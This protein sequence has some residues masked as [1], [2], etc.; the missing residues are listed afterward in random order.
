VASKQA[1]KQASKKYKKNMSTISDTFNQK[2]KSKKNNKEVVCFE[3]TN[4][5]KK[6]STTSSRGGG[7]AVVVAIEKRPPLP[8]SASSNNSND[9]NTNSFPN[10]EEWWS[11]WIGFLTF[12]FCTCCVSQQ[13]SPPT[14]GRWESN[15]WNAFDANGWYEFGILIVF[16]GIGFF[17]A[18]SLYC[19]MRNQTK[20]FP[21]R[22]FLFG[23]SVFFGLVVISK[24]LAAQANIKSA[25]VGDS[26]WA[27]AFGICLTNC[28]GRVPDWLKITMQTE[29][30]IAVSLVLLCVDFSLLL[31]I[32]PKTLLVCYIDVPIL[33]VVFS[34]LGWKWLR[35]DLESSLIMSGAALIC[36]SAAAM[37]IGKSLDTPKKAEPVIAVM[38]IGTIFSIIS[39]PYLCTALKLSDFVVGGLIGSSV[40]SVGAVIA[41]ASISGSREVISSAAIVKMVQNLSI[42]PIAIAVAIWYARYTKKRTLKRMK[43]DE[44]D[45]AA[46]EDEYSPLSPS[47]NNKHHYEDYSQSMQSL[48][49]QDDDQEH[50]FYN[51]TSAVDNNGVLTTTTTTKTT[52][53][54]SDLKSNAS[55]AFKP[56]SF[57]S[58]IPAMAAIT[59]ASTDKTTVGSDRM[60]AA[61]LENQEE[62]KKTHWLVLLWERFPKFVLGF[63][64][65]TV[66]F[67]TA[68]PKTMR[69]DTYSFCFCVAEYFSTLSFVSIGTKVRFRKD[70]TTT[71]AA[72]AMT[73]V[74]AATK[75]IVDD[76]QKEKHTAIL[77]TTTTT[78]TTTITSTVTSTTLLPTTYQNIKTPQKPKTSSSVWKLV[79]M[80]GIVQLVDVWVSLGLS[81]IAFGI[82]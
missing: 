26:I 57:S 53:T 36:G 54:S 11:V 23:Y 18:L 5:L 64:I 1:N 8:P 20:K 34:W 37:A 16:V 46:G 28:F 80:Y 63:L 77:T 76:N 48:R 47:V 67:N 73:T 79:V 62:N 78:T 56:Y 41:T 31:P 17:V 4:L 70:T 12:V 2:D 51:S 81:I 52:A 55:S 22:S 27:I 13:V 58:N 50:H 44:E 29:L 59:T 40:D 30:Y 10:T 65:V 71:T 42:A 45:A 49:E 61:T 66:V 69:A 9:N 15:P 43:N 74:V 7:G 32:L 6:D 68:V 33:F 24:F 72:A 82:L 21:L 35:V 25:G 60:S 3:P 14:F 19:I 38:S 75:N 39:L